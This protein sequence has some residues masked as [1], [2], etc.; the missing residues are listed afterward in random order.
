MTLA[1][2]AELVM[3]SVVVDGVS[4]VLFHCSSAYILV[5]LFEDV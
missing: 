1:L 4:C 2:L 5:S 3:F